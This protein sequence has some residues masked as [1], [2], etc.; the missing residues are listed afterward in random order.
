MILNTKILNSFGI[1]CIL[2]EEFKLSKRAILISAYITRPPVEWLVNDFSFIANVQIIARLSPHD[3]HVGASSIDAVRLAIEKG[4]KVGMVDDLHAKAYVL[5]DRRIFVGSANFTTSGLNLFGSGNLEAVVEA[6]ASQE[7]MSFI[8]KIVQS[9]TP[10]DLALLLKMEGFLAT[11][12]DKKLKTKETPPAM[13]P[14]ALLPKDTGIWVNDFPLVSLESMEDSDRFKS[15]DQEMFGEDGERLLSSKA[16]CWLL[17][18]IKESGKDHMFFGELTA[19]LHSSLND[20]PAPFRRDVKQLLASLLTYCQKYAKEYIAIDIPH[21]HSER[22][23]ILSKS[24][25]MA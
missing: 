10:I 25:L 6:E 11:F 7:N 3:F 12:S 5:D 15:H 9:A 16:F 8:N 14:R 18:T 17:R 20:D 23:T 22:V 19:Q 2:E 1:K 21:A 13:W 4:I 24:F